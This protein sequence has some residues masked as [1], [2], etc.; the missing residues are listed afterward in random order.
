MSSMRS[1]LDDKRAFSKAALN[2]SV[3]VASIMRAVVTI[4]I[5]AIAP[6]L[7][8]DVGRSV[9]VFAFTVLSAAFAAEPL[10]SAAA[11]CHR[12]N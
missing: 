11:P 6:T 2:K 10:S 4:A 1:L 12:D 5:V 3:A 7:R 8:A 9:A